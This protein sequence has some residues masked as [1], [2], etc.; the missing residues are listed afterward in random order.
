MLSINF[1]ELIWTIINFFLLFFLLK[2]FLF[3]PVCRFMDERQ[4]RVDAGLEAERQAQEDLKENDR[5]LAEQ[6]A[7]AQRQAKEL[8]DA[9]A[10]Q[11]AKRASEAFVKARGDA[12]AL[13]ESEQA[14]LQQRRAR[15]EEALAAKGPELASLLAARLLGEEE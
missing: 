10:A 13:Q 15:E 6:R 5:E 4:A 1:S 2:R 8:L 11:D 7:E 9:A 12:E 3:D 14:A